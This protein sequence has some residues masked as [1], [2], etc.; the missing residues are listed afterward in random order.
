NNPDI[1]V[2][3]G[4][5]GADNATDSLLLGSAAGDFTPMA[6]IP[7]TTVGGGNRVYPFD[8]THDGLTSFLVLNG[9]TPNRGPTQ[10]LTPQP[11]SLGTMTRTGALQ[12]RTA[13]QRALPHPYPPATATCRIDLSGRSRTAKRGRKHPGRRRAWLLGAVTVAAA[14]ALV[15]TTRAAAGGPALGLRTG[16]A[17][18]S[19]AATAPGPF[20][21]LLFSR[22]EISA[23]D[24]CIENDDSIAPLDTT[25]PPSL[26]PLALPRPPPP[27]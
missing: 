23:A 11:S 14:V 2:V 19:N 1:Y 7:G 22:T 8:Y 9:Q 12:S 6:V 13:R 25:V 27:P 10:L 4:R 24:N 17:S 21:T 15:P 16:A 20:V 3:C 5:T 26:Q 18:A